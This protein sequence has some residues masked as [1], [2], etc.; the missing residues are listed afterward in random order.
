MT[1]E[2]TPAKGHLLVAEDDPLIRAGVVD[3]LTT[4]GYQISEAATLAA[5]QDLFR[6]ARVDLALV[7]YSFPDGNALQLLKAFKVLDRDVPVIVLTGHGSIDLAVRAIKE[8]AEQFLTK[9]IDLSSL[10]VFV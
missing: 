3:Y 10:L 8:G 9:P 5:A 1:A 2:P 7:D 4:A 6:T